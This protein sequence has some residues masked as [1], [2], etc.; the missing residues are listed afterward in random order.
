[1][2]TRKLQSAYSLIGEIYC[3]QVVPFKARRVSLLGRKC[4]AQIMYTFLG[5]EVKAAKKRL[6][7]PDL[8]TARYLKIFLE[9][10]MKQILVPYD[11]TRTSRLIER[12]E[13]SLEELKQQSPEG[14]SQRNRFAQV[15]RIL[16]KCQAKSSS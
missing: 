11:P 14:R 8:V 15:R 3:Q 2:Q 12:L 6:T 9:L 16:V 5:Y 1:M 4:N 7:C 13:R 10:G